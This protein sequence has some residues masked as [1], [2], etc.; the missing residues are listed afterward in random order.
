MVLPRD[1][2]YSDA[3]LTSYDLVLDLK[4]SSTKLTG[5]VNV[6]SVNAVTSNNDVDNAMLKCLREFL[7]LDLDSRIA[8]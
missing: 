7:Y 4:E 1:E 6:K 3:M 8:E 2:T 5:S